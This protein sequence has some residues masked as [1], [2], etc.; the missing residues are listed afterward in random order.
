MKFAVRGFLFAE[1]MVVMSKKRKIVIIGAGHVGSHCAQALCWRWCFDEIVLVDISREK[2]AAQAMDIA[3][4]L[5]FPPASALVRA[6]DYADCADADIVVVSI[7]KARTPGQTRL[8]LLGDSVQIARTLLEQLRPYPIPGIVITITN[9]ADIVADYIRKGLGLPRNR[10]FST[11]TLLDTAR[12]IRTLSEEAR[13]S[14]QSVLAFSM[15]EHGDS[16][17]IPFSAVRI[18]GLPLENYTEVD[19]A[20]VLERTRMIGMDIINGKGS[21][22]FGIGQSLAMLAEAIIRDQKAVLP[23][24]VQLCGEYGQE[25]VHCGVPCVVGAGGAEKIIELPL[26]PAEQEQLD[27]SCAVI[28]KHIAMAEEIA[29]LA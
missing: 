26:T 14:R 27:A 25:G 7:G 10:V 4:S 9:P 29:P 16:S 18:G 28:R 2:A 20:R 15:G 22:E 5:S 21:T 19:P 24:S 11:G 8:D 3:D 13:V 23:L 1:R 6:G 12:L 17:M